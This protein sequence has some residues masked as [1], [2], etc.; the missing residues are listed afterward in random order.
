MAV[1]GILN[2]GWEHGV[3]PTV[4]GGGLCASV[5]GA[6]TV[7]ASAVCGS[8]YVLR[9]RTTTSIASYV[10]YTIPGSPG[11]LAGRVDVYFNAWPAGLD[12]V[13]QIT[14]GADSAYILIDPSTQKLAADCAGNVGT[15]SAALSLT[16]KYRIDFK[17][18]SSANPWTLDFSIN[19]VAQAQATAAQAASAITTFFIN[20][21]P[22]AVTRDLY[23]DNLILSVT[24]GDYP[25]GAGIGVG[26]CPAGAGTSVPGTVIQDNG[27]VVVNDS[28]NPANIELKDVPMTNTTTYIVSGPP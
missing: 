8:S 26:L 13:L 5:T 15:Y 22:F 10:G 24:A 21:V 19:G 6:P 25:I 9:V 2:T 23:F 11:V 27:S 7:V 16:T 1:A 4:N 3:A 20:N 18:N 12:A 14:N 17:F 28:S